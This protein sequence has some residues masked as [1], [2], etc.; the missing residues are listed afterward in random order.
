MIVQLVVTYLILQKKVMIHQVYAGSYV[1]GG[2][3]NSSAGSETGNATAIPGFKFQPSKSSYF[4]GSH[5][6]SYCTGPRESSGVTI[7]RIVARSKSGKV[8]EYASDTGLAMIE[9]FVVTADV[10]CTGIVYPKTC[11]YGYYSVNNEWVVL[12]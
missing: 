12:D 5:N 10:S 6:L 3:L 9:N 4:T 11:V 7:F 1:A 2:S 8:F